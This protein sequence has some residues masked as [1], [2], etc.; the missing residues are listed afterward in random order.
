MLLLSEQRH[1]LTAAIA[2]DTDLDFAYHLQLQEAITASQTTTTEVPEPPSGI[3]H[4]LAAEIDRF[5]RDYND[6]ELA[7]N[8]MRKMHENVNML[9][10]DQLFA[11]E[12]MDVNEHEWRERGDFFEKPF[13]NGVGNGDEVFRVYCKGILSEENVGG[14]GRVRV[15]GIGVA[16]CDT[17]D[18]C[19]FEV[20]KGVTVSAE[21]ILELKSV[22]EGL[23]VA[24]SLGLRRV[25][26]F[27]DTNAVYG[28]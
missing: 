4:L 5:N 10:H 19:V 20:K 14:V 26:V 15:G 21:D 8:E 22:I 28:Y 18:S 13:K 12:V 3:A 11:R 24:V 23:S 16:I 6:R 9:L 25:R 17:R 27:C 1:E 7:K 2:A